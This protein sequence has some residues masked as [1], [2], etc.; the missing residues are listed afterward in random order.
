MEGG[1]NKATLIGV[2]TC[3][4]K[5][6][7][8]KQGAKQA[9]FTLATTEVWTD[10]ATNQK[11]AK[12]ITHRI[13]VYTNQLISIVEKCIR[14]GARAYIEGQ[15]E[16]RRWVSRDGTPTESMT[17]E[18]VVTGWSGR[19]TVLDFAGNFTAARSSIITEDDL[20][21]STPLSIKRSSAKY[22]D[23]T[24]TIDSSLPWLAQQKEQSQ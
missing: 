24:D 19:I 9:F 15:I 13:V 6:N 21:A 18:I 2:V 22:G 5:I 4:P 1:L 16:T 7:I 14:K 11:R 12:T 10:K 3:D 23:G 20:D 8:T 17:V